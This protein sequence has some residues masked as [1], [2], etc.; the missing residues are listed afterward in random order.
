MS[1]AALVKTF[2]SGLTENLDARTAYAQFNAQ[3]E[4]VI[5][6]GNFNWYYKKAKPDA[7]VLVKAV[8]HK[9]VNKIT[10]QVEDDE[11][12]MEFVDE[13]MHVTEKTIN[14][15]AL[16]PMKTNTPFDILASKRIGLSR[17]TVYMLTGES[18]AGKTTIAT[19]IGE[20]IKEVDP[21]ATAG[22]ISGEM[23]EIDWFE[24]CQDNPA[25][26]NLN[27]VYLLKYIGA[28]NFLSI[29][30]QAMMKY[31][32]VILDS[33]ESVL[34]IIKDVTGFS[35]KKAERMLIDMMKKATFDKCST[36]MAIQQYTKG[37]TY[38]G[39]TKLK[40][41]TTGLIFVKFDKS[42]GRYLEFDKNRRCGGMIKKRLYYAKNKVTGRIEFDT[43][44]FEDQQSMDSANDSHLEE[45]KQQ[46]NKFDDIIESMRNN[47]TTTQPAASNSIDS[48]SAN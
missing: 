5:N 38:V 21:T 1:T 15:K 3:N 10:P 14:P 9:T 46:G 43:K 19:N 28:K 29:L 35:A 18:G 45:I 48:E 17:S 22:F 6:F 32:Y 39:S 30:E 8:P 40:H 33:M 13:N 20:Y 36:I 34:D 16:I 23:D 4:G 2:I 31:D 44:R 25:L 26:K 41:M 12:D 7:P 42:G 37:G 11:V 47:T 24:E 27:V